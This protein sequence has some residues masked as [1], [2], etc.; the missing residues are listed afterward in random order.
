MV[1]TGPAG[2][3]RASNFLIQRSRVSARNRATSS[4]IRAA[5]LAI[6]LALLV[7]RGSSI[8]GLRSRTSQKAAQNLLFGTQTLRYLA[9]F[10]MKVP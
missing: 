10:V 1:L 2:M 7:K 6:R 9:S 3:P 5:R 8:Q 4:L